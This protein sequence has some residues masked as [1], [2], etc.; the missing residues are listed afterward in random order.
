MP[1]AR[2]QTIEVA[3]NA[4]KPGGF[5][6]ASATSTPFDLSSRSAPRPPAAIAEPA[7]TTASI[8]SWLKDA[9]AGADRVPPDLALAYAANAV[10]DSPRS[11]A[12][13][14]AMS[15]TRLAPAPDASSQIA[16]IPP[17]AGQ[18]YNDP[19][20]R[21]IT[22]ATSVHY[23]MNVSVYGKLD[24][25]HIRMMMIKPASSLAMGFGSDAYEGMQTLKFAGAAVTFL[26]TIEFGQPQASLR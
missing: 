22:L 8:T 15:A 18:R 17:K 10:P 2:P 6:L 23:E 20:L 11:A 7:E 26:P 1:Q 13:A 19:W 4:R 24:V 16:R 9:D 12:L 3:A 25:R 14:P 21:G 5:A